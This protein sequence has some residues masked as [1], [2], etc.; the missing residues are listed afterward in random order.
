MIQRKFRLS[1]GVLLATLLSISLLA[2]LSLFAQLAAAFRN[3][4]VEASVT[5]NPFAGQASAVSAGRKLFRRHCAQCH[6]ADARG[7]QRGPSLRT[8]AVATTPPGALF[9]FVTNGDLRRGMPP[10]SRIPDARRWQ[11]VSFLQSLESE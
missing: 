8:P 10:W 5:P 4:P 1:A 6:G 7:S 9:W 2:G 3:A 11:L